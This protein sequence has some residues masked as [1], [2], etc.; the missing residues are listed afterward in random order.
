[1]HQQIT[2]TS[3]PGFETEN[4]ISNSGGKEDDQMEDFQDLENK[5]KKEDPV[6]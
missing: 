3:A 6:D 5:Q 1:M 4:K 2:C